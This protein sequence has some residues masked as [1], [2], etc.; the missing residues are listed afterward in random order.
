LIFAVI[1]L[2]GGVA[3]ALLL[4]APDGVVFVAFVFVVVVV[5]ILKCIIKLVS[6]RSLLLLFL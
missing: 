5:A 4:F 3:G 6:F 1:P 2:Y